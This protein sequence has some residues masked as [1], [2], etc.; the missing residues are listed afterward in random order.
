ML[1]PSTLRAHCVL[2]AN[3]CAHARIEASTP[4]CVFFLMLTAAALRWCY[5]LA[6]WSVRRSAASYN[7]LE[8]VLVFFAV[9]MVAEGGP[10]GDLPG[11]LPAPHVSPARL[12]MP[13]YACSPYLWFGQ[14]FWVLRKR[15]SPFVAA[16]AAPACATRALCFGKAARE[17]CNCDSPCFDY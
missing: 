9:Q 2:H 1:G 15:L 5:M 13:V 12:R 7:L 16:I 17:L 4:Q 10:S 8:S 6:S 11:T 3:C 14:T